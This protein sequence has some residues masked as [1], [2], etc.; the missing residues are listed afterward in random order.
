MTETIANYKIEFK[1]AELVD[2][3]ASIANILKK[4]YEYLYKTMW[5]A[6]EDN[7]F[8]DAL[9]KTLKFVG[10]KVIRLDKKFSQEARIEGVNSEYDNILKSIKKLFKAKYVPACILEYGQEKIWLTGH[11]RGSIFKDLG[12]EYM[13]V[14]VYHLKD[15]HKGEFAKTEAI[16]EAGQIFQITESAAPPSKADV[17]HALKRLLEVNETSKGAYGIENDVVAILDKAI[18]LSGSAFKPNTIQRMAYSVYNTANPGE[19]IAAWS[20]NKGSEFNPKN[21]RLL[22]KLIDIPGKVYYLITVSKKASLV[23][24][25]AINLSNKHPDAEIRIVAHTGTLTINSAN[26]YERVYNNALRTF[27]TDYDLY[28]S[29]L[30]AFIE[31]MEP[32][33]RG[34]NIKLYGAYP[35]ISSKHDMNSIFRFSSTERK[36]Y[37]K[38]R[39]SSYEIFIDDD[40]SDSSCD[41]GFI[42]NWINQAA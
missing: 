38:D 18:Q 15:G 16:L 12:I 8:G 42:A 35:A 1:P 10:F 5:Q 37:Q 21:Y 17:E 4:T 41:S 32:K 36:F 30:N 33:N 34:H 3:G 29:N 20:E 27:H 13:V 25:N 7:F 19:K 31:R 14:A 23:W 24:R 22:Y 28:E 39:T 40:S 11:T 9:P 2:G 26:D 6:T